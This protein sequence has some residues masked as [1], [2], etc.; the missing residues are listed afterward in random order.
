MDEIAPE[1]RALRIVKLANK[2]ADTAGEMM[3]E[4]KDAAAQA[5]LIEREP[6]IDLKAIDPA[7]DYLVSQAENL[8]NLRR[9][10]EKVFAE[11]DLFFDPSWDILLDLFIAHRTGR[12]ISVTSACGAAQVPASTAMRWITMLERMGLIERERD[13]KDTRRWFVRL[14]PKAVTRLSTVLESAG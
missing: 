4:Q 11:K 9:K 14:T 2:I 7:K 6:F 10:R 1:G 8:Y 5:E 13:T 3:A 12:Q